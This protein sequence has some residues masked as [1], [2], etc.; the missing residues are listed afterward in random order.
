[1]ETG[2]ENRD[3]LFGV[4]ILAAGKSER[5]GSPKPLLCLGGQTI[6][7][8]ILSNPFLL[9]PDVRSITVLGHEPERIQAAVSSSLPYVVNPDYSKGRTTSV[10]CG[11]RALPAKIAGVFIWPVDCPLIPLKVLEML[12]VAFDG[13]DSIRIPSFNYKRGHPPLIGAAYFPEIFMMKEDQSLRD[14]YANHPDMI[15][16]VTVDTDTILHNLNTPDD[17]ETLCNQYERMKE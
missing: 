2:K 6:L 9:R 4:I 14:L 10:Q 5:M 1:M 16:H 17:F 8:R 15:Q 12:A 3:I 13:P 7:E 11:L